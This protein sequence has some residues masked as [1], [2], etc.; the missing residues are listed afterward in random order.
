MIEGLA[1]GRIVHFAGE[2]EVC[3]AIV[4]KVWDRETGCVTP[5]VFTDDSYRPIKRE[6]SRSYSESKEA[7]TWHWPA[8]S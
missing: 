2:A 6:T 4:T 7:G 5:T 1:V 3:A 8:R